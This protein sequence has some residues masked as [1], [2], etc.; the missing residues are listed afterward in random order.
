MSVTVDSNPESNASKK[1][2]YKGIVTG[3]V[4]LNG[5]TSNKR[6]YH[7]VIKSF[8]DVDY[9]PGDALGIVPFNKPHIVDSIL[10]LTQSNPDT[11][12]THSKI[13][14]PTRQLL[15]YHLNISYLLKSTIKQYAALTNHDIP[16]TRLSLYD[17]LRT[18]PLQN[19][20]QFT[21]VVQL[22]SI[23]APRLYSI[24]SSPA[25]HGKREIHI[26][27]AKDQFLVAQE[28]RTGVGSRYLAHLEPA[29]ELEF[30]IQKSRHFKLPEGDKDVIMVGPGTGIAPFRSFL[31][32]RDAL[33][34]TGRN[35]LFFGEQHIASDFLY[36]D[37]IQD[38]LNKKIL[39][40][41]D[42][43]F[44][45]DQK[46]KIYVQTRLNEKG[47]ELYKWFENGAYFFICGK[48]DPMSK[49]VEIALIEIIKTHGNKNEEEAKAYLKNLTT[50][51]RYRK[52]VY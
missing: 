52:D 50:S 16:D 23:Q 40:T 49:D 24:S 7:I 43:A 42:G 17:L 39:T 5:E 3:S 32:E 27:V 41:F 30:F 6:T 45:R 35:W 34:N 22:L 4:N 21:E 31:F 20:I 19:N 51:G 12:I 33:Q 11:I 48:R 1:K 26:T 28:K 10:S 37:E 47:A 13:T 9:L 44:S 2:I 38:F 18:Y 46:E 14:A 29:T 8:E 15:Q 36:R 25:A